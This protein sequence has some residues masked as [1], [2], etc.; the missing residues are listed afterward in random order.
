[1]S[2]ISRLCGRRG[3]VGTTVAT[4]A[5]HEA[6]RSGIWSWITTTDHKRIGILYGASAF[7]F[8]LLGGLEAL[9]IRL[10][11]AKADNTLIEAETFNQLFTMHGTTMVF[12]AIMPMSAAFFNFIIPLQIGA[13]DVAFPRLNAFSYWV[14]LFGGLF[15]NASF[16]FGAAPNGGWFG[17]ANLT[18]TQYSPGLNIDFWAMGLQI[19]GIA[20]LAAGFNFIA[21]I[22]NMRAPGMKLMRMPVFT[23]MSFITQFLVITAF[24]VITVALVF[25]MFDRI[26][27]ATFYSVAAGGNLLLWQHLFWLFGHPEVYILILPAMG[28]V[29]EVLPTFSRKPLFGYPVIVYSGIL[30]GVIGWAVWSHHMFAT[31]MGPIAD[32]YFAS[33]TMLIAIP[34]G[35]KIFN[36]IATMW[37]GQ[38]RLTTPM[39][40]AVAFIMLFTI[41][42]ISGVMHASPPTDLQQT[43]TYFVVAH[44]H[45][46][47]FG[48]AIMG[49]YA[50]MYYWWPKVFGRLLDERLGKWHFWLT[51]IGMNLSFFPMHLSG[52]LG[53]PRRVY[54]YAPELGVEQLNLVSTIGALLIGLSM[55]FMVYNIWR[56]AKHGEVAGKNPWGAA[57]LEWAISS[58]PPVYNFSV[59]PEVKSRLPLWTVGGVSEIPDVPPEPVH[60]PGGSYWPVVAAFGIPLFFTG[61][62]VH[63]LWLAILGAGWTTFSVF[64]WAFE[65]FEM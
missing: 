10:Q 34:T 48:G 36:W 7:V 46:V 40:F 21:T 32:S 35:V 38:I 9:L 57:T 42:G 15:I 33:V 14:F 44:I 26:F 3:P 41:G 22:I 45:Y 27:G 11:L 29:S 60:V 18:S 50:A 12:L 56:S 59:I 28:M 20:S 54:T 4:V 53:M 55:F 37:G 51:F 25:L 39:L 16:L 63:S 47:L 58:P 2:R 23:W 13:R 52:L 65:P 8:F 49:I 30:I 61:A 43:D 5:Q 31:G 1:M 19:L 24:P 17:Y 62:L 64:K 6:S